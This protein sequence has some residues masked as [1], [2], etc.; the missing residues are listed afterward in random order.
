VAEQHE[1]EHLFQSI[2]DKIDLIST[3]GK[4]NFFIDQELRKMSQNKN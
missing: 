3:S 2:L 1:E 4:G